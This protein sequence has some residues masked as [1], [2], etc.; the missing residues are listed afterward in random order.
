MEK[1][2]ATTPLLEGEELAERLAM[3][4]GV[5]RDKDARIL[6]R[7]ENIKRSNEEYWN[8][9]TGM[10]TDMRRKL[11]A[12]KRREYQKEWARRKREQANGHL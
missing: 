11:Q 3:I 1:G 5:E 4:D 12:E 9:V 8:R 2:R 7:R 10:T 6:K